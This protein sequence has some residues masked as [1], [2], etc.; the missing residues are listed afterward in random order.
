MSEET[1]IRYFCKWQPHENVG[2]WADTD[3]TQGHGE[4]DCENYIKQKVGSSNSI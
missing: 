2:V 1:E 3:K 4:L